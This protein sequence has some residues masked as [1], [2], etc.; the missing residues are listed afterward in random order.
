MAQYSGSRVQEMVKP[1]LYVGK[2]GF[3]EEV[4]KR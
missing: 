1:S 3:K 4:V 2:L